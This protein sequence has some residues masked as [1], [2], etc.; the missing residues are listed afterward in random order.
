MELSLILFAG[1]KDTNKIPYRDPHPLFHEALDI[2]PLKQDF[3]HQLFLWPVIL[4][5]IN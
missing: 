4:F 5:P 1:M 3:C 2:Y